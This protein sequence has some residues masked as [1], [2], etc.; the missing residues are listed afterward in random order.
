MLLLINTFLTRWKDRKVGWMGGFPG[1]T[2]LLG[3]QSA[4]GSW[5]ITLLGHPADPVRALASP[6]PLPASEEGTSCAALQL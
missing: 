6:L 1:R 2:G 4:S 5:C 3:L